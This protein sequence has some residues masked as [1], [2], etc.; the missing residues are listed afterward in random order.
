MRTRNNENRIDGFKETVENAFGMKA[1]KPKEMAATAGVATIY[2]L[3]F[4]GLL[5]APLLPHLASQSNSPTNNSPT[6]SVSTPT[7][8]D[9]PTG[10]GDFDNARSKSDCHEIFKKKLKKN[11]KTWDEYVKTQKAA[12]AAGALCE[13]NRNN[14][15]RLNEAVYQHDII[16]ADAAAQSNF[17]GCLGFGGGPATGVAIAGTRTVVHWVKEGAVAV[18]R[19]VSGIAGGIVALSSFIACRTVANNDLANAIDAAREVKRIQDE[20][21]RTLYEQ[22][23]DANVKPLQ[24]KANWLKSKYYRKFR[25]WDRQ[26]ER[27]KEFF[28]DQEGENQDGNCATID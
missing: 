9:H 11:K 2:G 21:A 28:E 12:T 27:C 5:F 14:S 25:Y 20:I 24:D 6:N 1:K 15:L 19:K 16:S 4:A 22:C 7:P 8:T 10:L 17:W 3:L 13:T 18:G 26:Y 23:Y